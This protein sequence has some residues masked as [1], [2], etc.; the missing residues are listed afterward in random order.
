MRIAAALTIGGAMA[1]AVVAC[2]A[3]YPVVGSF[4]DYNEVFIGEVNANLLK[5]TSVI[6]VKAQNSNVRCFGTSKVLHIPASNYVAGAFLIPHCGGQRGAAQLSC[7]DGRRVLASWEATSCTSGFGFGN[8]QRGAR[9]NFA[10]GMTTE[11]ARKTLAERASQVAEKPNLPAY[12]PKETRREKGYATGTGF[13]I[14]QN[15]TLVTNFHVIEDAEKVVVVYDGRELPAQFIKG[16]KQADVALLRV[17]ASAPF[18][19]I[20]SVDRVARGEEVFTLGYPLVT[21]Q[22]QQQKASFGRVNALTGA[23]D[24]PA[25]LQIDVPIQPGNS[26]GPLINARGNVV[27]VVTATLSTLGTLRAAGALPQ[28]VNY[29]VKSEKILATAGDLAVVSPRGEKERSFKDLVAATEKS[30]ALIIAR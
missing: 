19:K 22:G 1:L 10:F 13:F 2:T 20:E 21:I 23:M 18:L 6:E 15:G 14:N 11:D 26:G 3:T 29:A 27:G 25:F 30:V 16:D 8:D 17:E 28:N 4:E 7:D 24:D 12:R 5:G 9:F